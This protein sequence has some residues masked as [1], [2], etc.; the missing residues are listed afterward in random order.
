MWDE[1]QDKDVDRIAK[2]HTGKLTD[3]LFQGCLKRILERNNI[4]AQQL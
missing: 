2:K 3:A 4:T 1:L